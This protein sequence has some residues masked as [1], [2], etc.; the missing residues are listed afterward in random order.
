MT[1]SLAI[2]FSPLWVPTF[3]FP[4]KAMDIDCV[5]LLEAKLRDVEEELAL[6]KVELSACKRQIAVLWAKDEQT[7]AQK[8]AKVIY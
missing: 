8:Q 1:L 4:L 6:G 7:T 3:Q 2:Q 5:Q